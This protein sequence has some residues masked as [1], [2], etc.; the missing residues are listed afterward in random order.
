MF[1]NKP[2]LQRELNQSEQDSTKI[3]HGGGVNNKRR[4]DQKQHTLTRE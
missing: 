4:K 2:E 1:R 3:A